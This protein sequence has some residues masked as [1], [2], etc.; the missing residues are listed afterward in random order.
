[1][2]GVRFEMDILDICGVGER[3]EEEEGGR[4]RE[5]EGHVFKGQPW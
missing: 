2:G 1:M 3:G 4:K 5:R